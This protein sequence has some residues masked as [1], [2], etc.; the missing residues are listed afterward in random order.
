M[1]KVLIVIAVVVILLAGLG[2]ILYPTLSDYYN[3][4]HRSG[5]I[6]DYAETIKAFDDDQYNEMWNRAVRYN[7]QLYG[8]TRGIEPSEEDCIEYDSVLNV[9]DN[10]MMAYIDIPKIKC[11]LPLY[12]GTDEGTLLSNA[13]HIDTS[14]LP[15]GGVNTHCVISG[16]TGL[17]SAKLFTNLETM[18]VGDTFMLTTLGEILTYEVDQVLVVLP[19]EVSSLKIEPGQDYCTL[20]TCTPYGVNSHRL[21][22]RGERI[23]YE[24]AVSAVEDAIIEEAPASTWTQEYLRGIGYG[25]MGV[26]ALTAVIGTVYL[27]KRDKKD[28][29][30][31]SQPHYSVPPPSRIST[32]IDRDFMCPARDRKRSLFKRPE[33]KRGQHEI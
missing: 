3:R 21:L 12:H 17:P 32:R 9:T 5:A 26:A 10:G 4:L 27:R 19:W 25:L 33:R 28:K 18:Q 6:V 22:V 13:G 2:L 24:T 29:A 20:V 23:A 15:V 1:K 31:P 8:R 7:E 30:R 11:H 16:H 14:S